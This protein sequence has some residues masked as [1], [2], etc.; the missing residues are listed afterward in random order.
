MCT[1]PVDLNH[2]ISISAPFD[3]KFAAFSVRK[4]GSNKE[5]I[6]IA[7]QNLTLI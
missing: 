1:K 7:C 3:I 6:A 5:E 4:S 2:F